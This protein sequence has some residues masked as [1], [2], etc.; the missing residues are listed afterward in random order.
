MAAK[1]KP[2]P[3]APRKRKA[4]IKQPP[5]AGHPFEIDYSQ[6]EDMAEWGFTE[7]QMGA[8]IGM[9]EEG[10]RKRKGRD[11]LLASAIEKGRGQG[12]GS[13]LKTQY[14]IAKEGDKTMLIWLGK[15]RLGQRD[16]QEVDQ[17]S[18]VNVT[19]VKPNRKTK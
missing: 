5:T 11:P 19:I 9:G 7:A 8:W 13:L 16:K 2:K 14:D 18:T 6:I 1:K 12:E 4:K 10:F 15:Q 17:N 3:K